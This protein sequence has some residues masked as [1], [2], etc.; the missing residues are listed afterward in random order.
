MVDVEKNQQSG[1][2]ENEETVQS[3]ATKIIEPALQKALSD[4]REAGSAQEVV[5]ALANCYGGLL[6]DM[7]GHKAAATFLQSHAV[8]IASLEEQLLTN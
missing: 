2:A 5:S 6:V 4:A 8:H 7:M 1:M 3:I